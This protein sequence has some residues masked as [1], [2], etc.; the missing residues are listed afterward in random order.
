MIFVAYCVA[1]VHKMLPR[2]C[3]DNGSICVGR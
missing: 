2:K 3:Y 1:K